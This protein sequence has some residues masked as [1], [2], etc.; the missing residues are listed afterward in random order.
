MFPWC[1]I[2]YEHISRLVGKKH[3]LLTNVRKQDVA[4]MRKFCSVV[5]KS[6]LSLDLTHACVLDPKARQT[7]TPDD[8]LQFDSFIF[9]GILGDAPERGRTKKLLTS[10]LQGVV[11]RNLGP[12][13]MAT[14]NAV[15]AVKLI[16]EGHPL[17]RLQFHD[18]LELKLKRGVIDESMVLPFRYVLLKGKPLISKKL[19]AYLK[20][21]QSL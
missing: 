6:V 21:K 9:G 16:L 2:E 17:E 10:N 13:Q 14:D 12:R 7:L 19:I 15:L 4:K 8:A 5:T 20:K 18:N 3:V 1:V 11:A